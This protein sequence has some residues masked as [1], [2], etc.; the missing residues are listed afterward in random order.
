MLILT[1]ACVV[2]LVL[3]LLVLG[4]FLIQCGLVGLAYRVAWYQ[5]LIVSSLF[6]LI[7]G[8]MLAG[9]VIIIDATLHWWL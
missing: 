3:A 2:L 7:G 1:K 5:K 6:W 9:A 4:V 8:C